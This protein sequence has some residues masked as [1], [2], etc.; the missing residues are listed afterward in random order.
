MSIN[1]LIHECVYMQ[2]KQFEQNKSIRYKVQI[3]Y[4]N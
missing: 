1:N 3:R 4:V 2:I